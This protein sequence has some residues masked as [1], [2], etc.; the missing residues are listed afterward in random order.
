[1]QKLVEKDV[2]KI[3]KL[4]FEKKATFMIC[5]STGMAK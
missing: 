1:V 4:I 3:S 5:G 2:Q